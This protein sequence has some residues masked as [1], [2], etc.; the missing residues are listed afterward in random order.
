MS[1]DADRLSERG[2]LVLPRLRV[3]N[4]NAIS[5]PMTWGFPAIS[6]FAGLMTAL[7]RKLGP[8]ASVAFSGFGVLCHGFDP[9]VTEHGYTRRFCLTR[10]PVLQDGS[11]AAIVEEGR[12]HLDVTLVFAVALSADA[13]DQGSRQ[14]LAEQIADQVSQLRVAG[15]S[16]V[17]RSDVPQARQRPYLWLMPPDADEGRKAMRRL[18]RRWL[19]GYALV[20]RDDLLHKRHAEMQQACPQASLYDAWLDL[21]RWTHR[22]VQQTAVD[23]RTGQSLTEVRWARDPRDGWLVPIPVGYGALSPLYEPGTVSGARDMHTPARFV[24]SV[25]SIGQWIS[26]H[27]L[28]RVEDLLWFPDYDD[29]TGVYRCINSYADTPAPSDIQGEI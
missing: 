7:S 20:C 11:T 12:A 8:A 17:P 21:S 3:Q 19:P 27:R 28:R 9:Q 15:G 24:E 13:V 23:S 4:A 14:A 18:M 26:P 10:N 2:L 16:I 5:S 29:T 6:A 1:H 25:Y 22:A